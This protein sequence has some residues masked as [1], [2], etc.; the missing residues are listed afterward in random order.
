MESIISALCTPNETLIRNTNFIFIPIEALVSML[1]F[2]TCLNIK[3]SSKT[4]ATYIIFVTLISSIIDFFLPNLKF[5]ITITLFLSIKFFFKLNS[6][7]TFI[8]CLIQFIITIILESLYSIL[9]SIFFKTPY[10]ILVQLPIATYS[11]KLVTYLVEFML[12]TFIKKS[13]FNIKV[14]D[15]ISPKSKKIIISDLFVGILF[16]LL[17]IV[18]FNY[19]SISIP[20]YIAIINTLVMI[21]YFVISIYGLTKTS[22]LESANER[23]ENLEL[24]NKTLNLLHDNVRAFKHDFNNIV[25]AIGRIC[26]NR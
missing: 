8:A 10:A 3:S 23:I 16:M 9:S 11:F 18:M 6:I 12:Y 13:N 19:Y 21:S 14:L 2:T 1:L 7:E 17:Q 5:L 15:N 25:Q 4:K 26:Y 24:Y 20:S 22:N